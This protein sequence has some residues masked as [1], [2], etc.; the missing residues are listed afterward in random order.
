MIEL[1]EKLGRKPCNNLPVLRSEF[2]QKRVQT[3]VN[4]RARRGLPSSIPQIDYFTGSG[5]HVN[6]LANIVFS[7]ANSFNASI[8]NQYTQKLIRQ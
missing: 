6:Q 4:L 1:G 7:N 2:V 5:D 8:Q 3:D